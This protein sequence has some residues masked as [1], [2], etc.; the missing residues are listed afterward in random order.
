VRVGASAFVCGDERIKNLMMLCQYY[1]VEHNGKACIF[2]IARAAIPK[3]RP[4]IK[5]AI[6]ATSFIC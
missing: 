5:N 6:V 1:V 4:E 3:F 2:F